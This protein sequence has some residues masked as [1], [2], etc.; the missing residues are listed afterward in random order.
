[1][2]REL[3]FISNAVFLGGPWFVAIF[4]LPQKFQLVHGASGLRAGIQTMPFT[5]AAPIGSVFSSILAGK[6]KT[7]AIYMVFLSGVLQTIGFALLASLPESSQIPARTYG[8]Q[9][10]AGFG[11][12]I[13]I[14]T[15]LLMVPFVV[16]ARDKGK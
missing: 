12:G 10:I 11:C 3:T 6:L 1:L 15:L 13:N 2:R 7:P 9:V 8:F 4:Q 5:F 16:E 14:S